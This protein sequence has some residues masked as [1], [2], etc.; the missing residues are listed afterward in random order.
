[1]VGRCRGD[2]QVEKS[3]GRS[4]S[5]AKNS[6]PGWRSPPGLSTSPG[7]QPPEPGHDPP[8]QPSKRRHG[9]MTKSCWGNAARSARLKFS[10]WLHSSIDLQPVALWIQPGHP[11]KLIDQKFAVLDAT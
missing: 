6:P 9:G 3:T 5:I 11:L 4:E 7:R 8:A 10:G 1:V 2:I